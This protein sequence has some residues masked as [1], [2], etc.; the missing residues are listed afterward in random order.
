MVFDIAKRLAGIALLIAL[1]VL[2]NDSN[3]HR[4]FASIAHGSFDSQR[5]VV[6]PP[7]LAT[8]VFYMSRRLAEIGLLIASTLLSND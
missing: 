3:S 5:S 1:T 4:Q 7:G 6:G 8:M 2:S